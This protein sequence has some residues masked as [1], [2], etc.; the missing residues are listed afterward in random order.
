LAALLKAKAASV[1][2]G[3][4]TANTIAESI[5]RRRLCT[6]E[7]TEKLNRVKNR[8][9]P[10]FAAEEHAGK[11]WYKTGK[12]DIPVVSA[13][14]ERAVAPLSQYSNVIAS[15]K[16]NNQVLLYAKPEEVAAAR[17]AVERT[18]QA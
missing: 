16:S 13:A 2:T 4:R 14:R 1:A 18:F 9:G 17:T 5:R 6:E 10:L 3:S 15:I 8:L 7:E 11:S 12:T